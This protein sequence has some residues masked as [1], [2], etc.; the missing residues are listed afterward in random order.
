MNAIFIISHGCYLKSHMPQMN[1]NIILHFDSKMDVESCSY[2]PNISLEPS[3]YPY[4]ESFTHDYLLSFRDERYVNN[5]IKLFGIFKDGKRYEINNVTN[6]EFKDVLLSTLIQHIRN[7][8]DISQFYCSFCRNQC[9]DEDISNAVFQLEPLTLS[10]QDNLVLE[11]IE[12][13]SG[14]FQNFSGFKPFETFDDS[15]PVDYSQTFDESQLFADDYEPQS[16]RQK[17]DVPFTFN[18]AFFDSGLG[19]TRRRKRRTTKK[20]KKFSKRKNKSRR[21]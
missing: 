18:N 15:Q 4:I 1:S 12:F 7:T 6:G 13:D 3:S 11:D 20:R 19:G 16:K 17:Q 9:T 8:Y 21:L 2:E 14:D 5:D 10:N